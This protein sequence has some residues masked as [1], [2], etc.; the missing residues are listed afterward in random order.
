MRQLDL[1]V[2]HQMLRGAV[3][4][5]EDFEEQRIKKIIGLNMGLTQ[6]V[7]HFSRNSDASAEKNSG[8]YKYL[9]KNKKNAGE[10]LSRFYNVVMGFL[11]VSAVGMFLASNFMKAIG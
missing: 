7:S 6:A 1:G 5:N 3:T 9:G 4:F 11:F 8:G 10:K 2:Y